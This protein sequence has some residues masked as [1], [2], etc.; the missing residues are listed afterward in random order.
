MSDD[1]PTGLGAIHDAELEE[2]ARAAYPRDYLA[3]GYG[4][5]R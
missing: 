2:A 3:F 1:S 5:W 4:D